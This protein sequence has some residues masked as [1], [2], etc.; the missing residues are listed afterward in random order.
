M[1]YIA[2]SETYG[3]PK[4]KII[5]RNKISTLIDTGHE[6]AILN[7]QLYSTLRLLGI[8]CLEFPTQHLS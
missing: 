3:C 7:E 8:N 5:M 6:M 4:I 2:E 1:L